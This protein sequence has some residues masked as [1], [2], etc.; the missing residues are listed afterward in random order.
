[1]SKI[2]FTSSDFANRNPMPFNRLC[3]I[4][5]GGKVSNARGILAVSRAKPAKKI[6]GSWYF[7][8]VNGKA[9]K[10][11]QFCPREVKFFVSKS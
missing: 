1:M 7:H 11:G 6:N 10:G 3:Y 4:T 9:Y 5:V 2:I 8:T